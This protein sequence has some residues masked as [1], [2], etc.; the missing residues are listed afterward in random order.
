MP[1]W[2]PRRCAPAGAVRP[3]GP[4]HDAAGRIPPLHARVKP[5]V[6]PGAAKCSAGEARPMTQV[7]AYLPA[8]VLDVG[9]DERAHPPDGNDYV[10]HA[11][12]IRTVAR[13]G[14]SDAAVA[15]GMVLRRR[16]L[17]HLHRA[18]PLFEPIVIIVE[19]AQ[20]GAY[21][22]NT[23]MRAVHECVHH[24][25]ERNADGDYRADD[26]HSVRAHTRV[27]V[28]R[29]SEP[30][31]CSRPGEPTDSV[32]RGTDSAGNA[33]VPVSPRLGFPVRRAPGGPQPHSHAIRVP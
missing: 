1:P 7:T 29:T 23:T 18:Q 20:V 25:S 17:A 11:G 16:L 6:A 32:C 14:M 21:V 27:S 5:G 4:R 10:R 19:T 15:G 24:A 2:T 28:P 9:V 26:P 22:V 8:D 33:E 12:P 3:R 30:A 13:S 31:V